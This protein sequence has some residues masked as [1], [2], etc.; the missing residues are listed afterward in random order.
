MIAVRPS[1]LGVSPLLQQGQC[2]LP[3]R[4]RLTCTHHCTVGHLGLVSTMPA[5]QIVVSK[6]NGMKSTMADI[7]NGNIIAKVENLYIFIQRERESMC[8]YIYINR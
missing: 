2:G 4:S 3:L 7:P 5:G 6:N 1:G 8:I